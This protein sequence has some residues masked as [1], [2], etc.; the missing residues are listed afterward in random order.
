MHVQYAY[1]V[2]ILL[3][4]SILYISVSS[5]HPKSTLSL[6]TYYKVRM[7]LVT[8]FLNVGLFLKDTCFSLG[9]NRR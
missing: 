6:G 5:F 1:I 9:Q 7:V 2:H 8:I 4:V 3:C